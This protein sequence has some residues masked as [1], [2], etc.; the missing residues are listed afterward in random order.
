LVSRGKKISNYVRKSRSNPLGVKRAPG[1]RGWA[2]EGEGKEG[3]GYGRRHE[4][5]KE[6]PTFAKLAATAFITA[7]SLP[8]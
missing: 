8:Y 1:F 5:G 4:R 6:H 2:P 3:K 7:I